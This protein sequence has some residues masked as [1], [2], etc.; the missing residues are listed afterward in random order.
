MVFLTTW[1][2]IV[3]ISQTNAVKKYYFIYTHVFVENYKNMYGALWEQ[4]NVK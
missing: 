4:F 2:G 1:K 3:K